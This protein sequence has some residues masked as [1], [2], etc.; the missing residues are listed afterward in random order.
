MIA[1]SLLLKALTLSVGI[2]LWETPYVQHILADIRTWF[3][4][5][6][7][8]AG[9]AV[10]YVDITK[11]YAVGVGLLYWGMTPIISLANGD[12]DIILLLHGILASV[13]DVLNAAILY[14]ILREVNARL[15]L[16]LTMFFVLMPTALVLSP[17]RFESYVVAPV[18]LGYW[19]HLRGRPGS[20]A[21]FW[22]LGCWLKWFPAF[23]IA[24]Q[25]ISALLVGRRHWQWLR[26][27]GIFIGVSVALNLPFIVA[28][29]AIHGNIDN[30]LHPYRFHSSR[31]IAGDTVLGVA[32]M[33]MG[34]LSVSDYSN[35]WTMGLVCAA[36]MV[37]PTLRIE[38]RFLLVCIAMLVLNRI[39]SPQFNLW[40]YPFVILGAAQE[41]P[42]RRLLLLG[43]LLGIDLLN[44][45]VFPVSYELTWREVG[46]SAPLSA[47][48]HAGAW[49]VTFSLAVVMRGMMLVAL[50]LFVL[51][52]R[53]PAGSG[54]HGVNTLLRSELEP[55]ES[56]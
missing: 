20:A 3:G 45:L 6:K 38:Y 56:K 16:P 2:V 37:K 54:F 31:G 5:W 46:S 41:A 18:L 53:S 9:G 12:G 52:D 47:A 55:V 27:T 14:R 51:R 36:L 26:V 23:F 49:T 40:F 11:E 42:E 21:F 43:M 13:M 39:Y 50:A 1:F 35:V 25:E 17:Q 48:T 32:S 34:K 4:F 24:A 10:P 44:V 28:N 33:W 7:A 8:C 15:A 29:L 19:C 22:S 30:W